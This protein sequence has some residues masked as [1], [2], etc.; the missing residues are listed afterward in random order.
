MLGFQELSVM[1]LTIRED[2]SIEVQNVQMR[3]LRISTA[4][5]QKGELYTLDCGDDKPTKIF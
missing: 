1:K 4:L 2:V 3:F 5:Q